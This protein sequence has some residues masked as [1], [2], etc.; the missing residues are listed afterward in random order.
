MSKSIEGKY[1]PSLVYSS[2]IRAI[3]AGRQHGIEHYGD[4]ENWREVDPAEFEEALCRHAIKL[5]MDREEV[6]EDSGLP[7]SFLIA[8]NAMYI[9]EA[10]Y[11]LPH[12][13]LI[14]RKDGSTVELPE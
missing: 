1:R 4:S 8:V 3:V 11:G 5:V 6:D 2:L 10:R 13:T 7:H 9:I 14:R 12:R